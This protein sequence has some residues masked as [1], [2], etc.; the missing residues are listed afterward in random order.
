MWDAGYREPLRGQGRK[1]DSRRVA[2]LCVPS[3]VSRIRNTVHGVRAP[4][5]PHEA[6][7]SAASGAGRRRCRGTNLNHTSCL[8]HYYLTLVC[9]QLIPAASCYARSTTATSRHESQVLVHIALRLEPQP[10]RAFGTWR[11]R[12]PGLDG[13]NPAI[14]PTDQAR[15]PSFTFLLSAMISITSPYLTARRNGVGRAV[16]GILDR[17]RISERLS[18]L[19]HG[20]RSTLRGSLLQLRQH[21]PRRLETHITPRKANAREN[22]K[23]ANREHREPSFPAS[24]SRSCLPG[25]RDSARIGCLI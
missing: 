9:H 20:L 13:R 22:R 8:A 10:R 15:S 5:A 6:I 3:G 4:R 19:S 17:K 1:G 7:P 14:V 12:Y 23:A 2:P 25:T 16:R 24:R 11:G 21:T 18:P